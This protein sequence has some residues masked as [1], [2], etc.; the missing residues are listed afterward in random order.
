VIVSTGSPGDPFLQAQATAAVVAGDV[1]EEL[2]RV[3]LAKV[4]AVEP[5]FVVPIE[6]VKLRVDE[7]FST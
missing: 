7:W 3:L 2:H 6:T 4:P 5:F 1:A